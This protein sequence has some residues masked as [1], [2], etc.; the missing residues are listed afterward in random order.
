[1]T[2]REIRQ[3]TGMTQARFCAEYHIPRRT[4]E[5]WERGIRQC[6]PYVVLWLAWL[7]GAQE[8]K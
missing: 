3:F 2:I 4:L 1:M 5:D 8:R 7:T 6:P